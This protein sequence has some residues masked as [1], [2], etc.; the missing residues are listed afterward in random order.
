MT[1]TKNSPPSFC[2]TCKTEVSGNSICCDR[3]NKWCHSKQSCSGLQPKMANQVIHYKGDS[4]RIWFFCPACKLTHPFDNNNNNS[5]NKI[6]PNMHL[7]SKTLLD[8]SN[9]VDSLLELK[10][11]VNDLAKW[12]EECQARSVSVSTSSSPSLQL[13]NIE[14]IIGEQVTERLERDKRKDYLI[15]K[16]LAYTN[17]TDFLNQFDLLSATLLNKTVQISDISPLNP[18]FTRIKV[19]NKDDKISLLAN[20]SKLKNHS[21]YNSVFISRDLTRKQRDEMKNRRL[22]RTKYQAPAPPVATGANSEPI[23]T[24]NQNNITINSNPLLNAVQPPQNVV[25]SPPLSSPRINILT[26]PPPSVPAIENSLPPHAFTTPPSGGP[27]TASKPPSPPTPNSHRV[28]P[29]FNQSSSPPN[30]V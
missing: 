13:D 19:L 12:K 8:L 29:N 16:G 18:R 25:V 9:K 7:I 1:P 20:A 10:S 28:D 11:T 27:S 30:L 3:C 6:D 14:S 23:R 4:L 22:N 17:S 15:I 2:S 26:P 24:S 5:D 21:Q